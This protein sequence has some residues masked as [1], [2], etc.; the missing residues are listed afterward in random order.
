MC[1]KVLRHLRLIYVLEKFREK[2]ILYFVFYFYKIVNEIKK[3]INTNVIIPENL[4][5]QEDI[6]WNLNA[7]LRINSFRFESKLINAIYKIF[8]K[9]NFKF[10][11]TED[12]I[13]FSFE[14]NPSYL[15]ELNG[16]RLPFGCHG[17]L[18]Y[19]FNFWSK[20]IEIE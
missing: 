3:G 18:K 19:D 17:W 12:A 2:S 1:K 15:Y 10:P 20:F 16:H 7:P 11:T 14:V 13:R 9:I 6:F 4:F 5:G 8:F